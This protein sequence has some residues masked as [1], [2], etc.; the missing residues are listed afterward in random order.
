VSLL[1]EEEESIGTG[2]GGG[3]L[4]GFSAQTDMNELLAYVIRERLE[5]NVD[6]G[7][8]VSM[9]KVPIQFSFPS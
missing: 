8:Y 6:H 7:P 1:S 3:G 9:L 4:R 5:L 2:G